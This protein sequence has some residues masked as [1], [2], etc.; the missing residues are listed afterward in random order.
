MRTITITTIIGCLAL[1]LYACSGTGNT[2]TGG[3]QKPS[4]TAAQSGTCNDPKMVGN[5]RAKD[6]KLALLTI[7]PTLYIQSYQGEVLDSS[8]Y[9]VTNSVKS[10]ADEG[11]CYL[12]VKDPSDEVYEYAIMSVSDDVLTL[13]YLGRGN[14]LVYERIK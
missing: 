11:G 7:T 8:A 6:D 4:E 2:K 12:V 14:L 1:A 13:M 9:E 5:W 10:G 3:Q